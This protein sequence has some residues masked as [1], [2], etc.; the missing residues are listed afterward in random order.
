MAELSQVERTAL[1]AAMRMANIER[2]LSEEIWIAARDYGRERERA[3]REAIE[4]AAGDASLCDSAEKLEALTNRL[5][6]LAASPGEP[7]GQR[8]VDTDGRPLCFVCRRPQSEHEGGVECKP[9]PSQCDHEFQMHPQ[10]EDF[11]VCSRCGESQPDYGP[12]E[13]SDNSLRVLGGGK[14]ARDGDCRHLSERDPDL[15]A[16][17]TDGERNAYDLGGIDAILRTDRAGVGESNG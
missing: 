17:M 14:G 9:D 2:E 11:G 6:S 1:E 7:E 8:P 12:G 4:D 10:S 3:L 15:W 5:L 13:P 16:R